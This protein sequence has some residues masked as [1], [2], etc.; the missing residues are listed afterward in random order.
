MFTSGHVNCPEL[1]HRVTPDCR[2]AEWCGLAVCPRERGM[3]LMWWSR[4]PEVNW[5][6]VARLQWQTKLHSSW[7]YFLSKTVWT[8]LLLFL[9]LLYKGKAFSLFSF[10]SSGTFTDKFKCNVL[11][12]D[13][14]LI[15]K[16]QTV[17][18]DQ[19]STMEDKV[20]LSWT[21]F[22]SS[23]PSSWWVDLLFSA[24]TFV[25]VCFTF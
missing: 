9:S 23:F 3:H 11:Y 5:N 10:S 13:I 7:L 1:S 24:L 2:R 17:Y 14:F 15:L 18:F 20:Y 12:Y 8:F 6:K 19:S 21:P 22:L 25:L 4:M 16:L